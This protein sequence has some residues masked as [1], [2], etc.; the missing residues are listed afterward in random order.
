V[1]FQARVVQLGDGDHDPVKGLPVEGQPA[2]HSV[3]IDGG[4]LV[5][6]RYV[7]VQVGVACPGVSVGECG[8][9]Q[10]GGVDLGDTGCTG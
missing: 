9:D 7:G 10:A 2:L 5:G 3:G 1:C 6:D 8:A 4:D